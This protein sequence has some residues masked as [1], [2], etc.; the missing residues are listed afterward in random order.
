M[1]TW[2]VVDNDKVISKHKSFYLAQ[3]A[4]TR[5]LLNKKI[6]NH[7]EIMPIVGIKH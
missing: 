2:Q 1:K 6:S 5:H 7:Y 4:V 3:E